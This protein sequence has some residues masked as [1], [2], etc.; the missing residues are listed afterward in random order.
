M[1]ENDS[2]EDLEAIFKI[3]KSN[4]EI[5]HKLGFKR[6]ADFD[7]VS[8][9]GLMDAGLSYSIVK[10]IVDV[11]VKDGIPFHYDKPDDSWDGQKWYNFVESLVYAGI[12]TWEE[13]AECVLGELNPPQV[14]TSTAT[15]KNIQRHYPEKECMK[16]VM[17]WFYSQSGRCS[18]CGSRLH[19]E[20]DHIV[21]KEEFEK[22][23]RSCADA[24]T[25]DNLQL[26]CKRC[27]VIKRASHKLGGLSFQTA[28][29]ALM[30]IL[31]VYHP[32]TL[33]EYSDLCRRH[34]M[35]MA[36][37]RFQEAWAMAEWLKKEGKY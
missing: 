8:I 30:W 4:V 9:P 5:L 32:E 24:D 10:K 16:A 3:R 11:L 12:V 2:R 29:A 28:Q 19:I 21:S 17:E 13:V 18:S 6:L 14:G 7:N 15:N 25:L 34:G 27:N 35:T 1:E 20:V 36:S 22:S 23:G 31:L 37:V 33:E 26:L